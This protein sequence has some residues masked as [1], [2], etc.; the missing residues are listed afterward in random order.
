VRWAAPAAPLELGFLKPDGEVAVGGVRAPA[1]AVPVAGGWLRLDLD[2]R[3]LV[4]TGEDHRERAS[5]PLPAG[6]T[7]VRRLGRR[8]GRVAELL[9]AAGEPV[10]VVDL[11]RRRIVL[12][13][14]G[15]GR[16]GD[17]RRGFASG[18]GYVVGIRATPRW[19]LDLAAGTD[20]RV[21]APG[22]PFQR[23]LC[24]TIPFVATSGGDLGVA[25][26]GPEGA[27]LYLGGKGSP[28][29]RIGRPVREVDIASIVPHAGTWALATWQR[30]HCGVGEPDDAAFPDDVVAGPSLQLI[31]PGA[32]GSPLVL[33]R[34]AGGPGTVTLTWG[35]ALRGVQLDGTG[36][37]VAWTPDGSEAGVVLHD[38]ETGRRAERAGATLLPLAFPWP[39]L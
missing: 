36:T 14:A 15:L 19:Q 8:R 2:G 4:E 24:G 3:R 25:R 18:D 6:A 11:S 22:D 13:P 31:R 23:A 26:R 29:R 16:A 32:A 10:G 30:G 27:G 17:P 1:G 35:T 28:Y 39:V 37:C 12:V 5:V 33:D 9:G 7:E 21:D 20:R 38:L 34:Y